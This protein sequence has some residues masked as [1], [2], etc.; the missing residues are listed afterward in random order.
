MS[1]SLAKRFTELWEF[2]GLSRDGC[3]SGASREFLEGAEMGPHELE[4]A[5][6]PETSN[7]LCLEDLEDRKR[8]KLPVLTAGC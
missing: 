3:R 4:G 7:C 8:L 2:L 6:E 1:H 5:P